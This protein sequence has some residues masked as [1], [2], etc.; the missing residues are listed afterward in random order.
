MYMFEEIVNVNASYVATT[1]TW[2]YFTFKQ[3]RGMD[4]MELLTC[5]FAGLR[6]F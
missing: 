1:G 6:N 4:L 2:Y 3:M 5:L